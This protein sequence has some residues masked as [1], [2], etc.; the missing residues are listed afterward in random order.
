[1]A[2][3]DQPYLP[4]Y[5]QDY[6][7]DEKLNLCSLSTQGVYIKV[8]CIMHKSEEY[9]VILLKQKDKQNGSTR[10]N[11]A[12]KLAKLLPIHVTDIE[13]ALVELL[14][15][16]VLY[17][18]GDRL[19]QKRMIR[20]NEISLKRAKAGKK[21][22]QTTQKFAKAKNKANNEYEYEVN[23]KSNKSKFIAPKLEEVTKY[24]LQNGY[25]PNVAK[26]AFEYYQEA[27]WHD[28][29][30]KKIKNWKQK[31]RGVWFKEEN[32]HKPENQKKWL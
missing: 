32:L 23:N 26:K 10:L 5:V 17:I 25:D 2:L 8:M 18:D 21:G 14:D 29:T 3:R 16:R 20:D 11:F 30:G 13:A 9:G 24:F 15:E 19:C 7:T 4:L 31:M 28:S 1:M 12:Y 27:N 6:L 22:G